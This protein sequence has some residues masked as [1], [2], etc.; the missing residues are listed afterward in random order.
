MNNTE[1]EIEQ[2]ILTDEEVESICLGAKNLYLQ[3][4]GRVPLLSEDELKTAFE[5]YNNGDLS[6][7]NYI[8]EHNLRL[9]ISVAYKV[10]GKGYDGEDFLDVVQEGNLGLIK[11]VEKYDAEHESGIKF[12][13]FAYWWI[14]DAVIRAVQ[15]RGLVHIPFGVMEDI[16]TVKKAIAKL[17][18]ESGKM[19]S[20]DEIVSATGFKKSRVEEVFNTFG[21]ATISLQTPTGEEE[22]G[23]LSDTISQSTFETPEEHALRTDREATIQKLLAKLSPLEKQVVEMAFGFCGD[24]MTYQEIGDKLGFTRQ[25]AHSLCERAIKKLKGLSNIEELLF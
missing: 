22:D 21:T 25:R 15:D 2:S 18:T 1:K 14:Y 12:S 24:T 23:E 5:Q 9:V 3:E 17:E 10:L 6:M 13:S 7:R 8:V 20:I 11:A 16:C 4:I 19:P